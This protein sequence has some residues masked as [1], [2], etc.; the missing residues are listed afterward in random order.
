MTTTGSGRKAK[1]P[2]RDAIEG[3]LATGA[4]ISVISAPLASVFRW[5]DA[6]EATGEW[7]VLCATAA[8]PYAALEAHLLA[9]HDGGTPEITATPITC[10]D[11]G[12]LAWIAEEAS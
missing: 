11:A 9:A 2:A 3:R 7:R 4:Q 8:A 1:R 10:G 6:V 5:E 12:Y